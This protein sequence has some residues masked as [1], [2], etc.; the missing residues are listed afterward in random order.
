MTATLTTLVN[1]NGT[2]G[3]SPQYGNLIFDSNG[4][5]FGTTVGGG[6]N[7]YGTVFEIAK[8]A[9]GYASTPTILVSFNSSN[10]A[11]PES[12]LI[13]DA[14]GNLF[15]TTSGSGAGGSGTVF[16]LVKTGSGY[17]S[18]PTTLVTFNGINGSYPYD[19]LIAD[20]NGNLFGTTYGGGGSG[21]TGQGTVFEIAKTGS[22]YASTP[23]TLVAFNGANGAQ[24][25]GSL[26]ADANGNL[27][28]TTFAGGANRYGT[29]FE[30]AKTAN[31]YASTPTILVSFN[32]NNG[33]QPKGSLVIDADGNLFGTTSTGGSGYGTVFEI[34]K[35]GSGYASAPTTL[36]SFDGSNGSQPN[37]ALTIDANG[38]LFG[39][40][41]YGGANGVAYNS[42]T[43][44]EI[45]KTGSGYAS[46]PTT[47]VS[48]NS[49]N[50]LRPSGGLIAD[51]N[52]GLFGITSGGGAYGA[53]TVFEITQGDAPAL[54]ITGISPDN[55]AST[56]DGLTNAPTVTINGTID[57]ADAAQTISVYNG[58]TLVGT[59]TATADGH[60]SLTGVTLAQG[61]NSLTAQATS[62]QGTG[63]SPTYTAT[64]DTSPPVVSVGASPTSGA[65]HLGQTITL[66]L[67][68]NEAVKVS[69]GTPTLILNDGGL[70]TYD[71]AATATLGNPSK[72]AFTYTVGA[73]DT[74]VDTLAIVDRNLNGATITDLAGNTPDYSGLSVSFPG[75]SVRPTAVTAI[76]ASPGSGIETIGQ[77][78]TLTL[79]FNQS[80]TVSGGT[81]T[82]TLNNGGTAVY[83]AAATAALGDPTKIVLSYTVAASDSPVN[84]LAIV[85][86]DQNGA[87]IVDA[88]G[89]GPDFTAAF[90]SFPAIQILS[91]PAL[92]VTGI[93]PDNGASTSDGLTNAPTVTINGTIDVADAA[94]TI[95]VYNGTTLVGT[96]T[97]TADGHWSLTGV[98]LAQG[99]NSLT[100]RA[101][102]NQGTGTS[103]IFTAT[104]DTTPPVVSVG[105]SPAS[106]A[107][108]FG[109][110]ITLVLSFSKAVRVSGGTPTLSLNDGGIATYDAA[111]TAALGNPTK[112]AFSYT[113]GASDTPVDALAVVDHS[114][115][116][117][118]ITDLAG[119]APDYSGL[120]ASLPGLSV[121]PTAV[122]AV[123]ASPAS[124]TES[125]GQTITLTLVF[126]QGVTV[127]GGTPTFTLNNGGT[128]V[129]DAAATAAL[130][131]PTRMVLSYTVAATDSPVNSLA[132]VRGDQNGAVIVDAAGHGPDFTA[133]FTSF[134]AIH[135]Q[136]GATVVSVLASPTSGVEHVGD[137]MTFTIGMDRAVTVSGGTPTLKLSNNGTA[138]YDAAATAALGDPAKLVFSYTVAA[139]DGS[140]SSINPLYVAFGSQNGA[141]ILDSSGAASDFSATLTGFPGIQIDAT[142]Q[143][144]VT[145]VVAS[146]SG[147]EHA[148]DTIVFTMTMSGAVTVS[149][150]TPTFTLNNGGKAVYDAAATAALNDP[151]KLVFK[152]TVA[153]SDFAANGLTFVRGDQNGA[154]ILD[155]AW[156]GPDF[157]AAFTNFP[158]V[159]VVTPATAVTSLVASAPSQIN[160]P[161]YTMT[162]TMTMNRAVT[163]TGGTP[164]LALNDG[165]TA[166]Y[167][168]T[169][170]AALGDPTKL[171][172]T[173][174]VS[175]S[176]LTETS[177]AV[178]REDAN[179]AVIFDQS[180]A[181]PDFSGALKSFPNIGVLT[182]ATTVTSAAASPSSGTEEPGDV[183]TLTY[184]MSRAVTVTGG[185]PTLTLNDGGTATYDAAATAALG[186]PT[187][188]VFSYAVH[189]D[190]NVH[191]VDS[192]AVTQENLNG[193]VISDG[194]ARGAPDLSGMTTSFANLGVKVG[195]DLAN[196]AFGP[197]L[198]L[199]YA[200]NQDNSGGLLTVSDGNHSSVITLLGQYAA[201]DFHTWSDFH[202]GTLVTD[203]GLTGAAAATFLAS[204][205]T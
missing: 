40:T 139:S 99:A 48:F 152:Y 144:T 136:S 130:G 72:L 80:V 33:S 195:I 104:L 86:S 165:G 132:I 117:A 114:L 62:G 178:V 102:S 200:A 18:T 193:A 173:Y 30:I 58:T 149:G 197:S 141:A 70:A 76:V 14:N 181:S 145:S 199:G 118:A 11:N 38:N 148:G 50:G 12:G 27:F 3:S 51:A 127:S 182:P 92:T 37:D 78:I 45:A 101:T 175:A 61:A 23:T 88:A 115:N 174:T 71:A 191:N 198:T 168:A 163:V 35:T 166:T 56:S 43:V 140:V 150:G 31:G 107:E 185:T 53:G 29:V 98:T 15:G 87:V 59:T 5:L 97:A 83:D 24:P 60:W 146:A 42:G 63:T 85:R 120:S 203:P 183:I 156:H 10:G 41:L 34:A 9:N 119:N 46:T 73:S 158:D 125:I 68:F 205:H 32:G 67:S 95:S 93:S 177:L 66:V 100:A 122:T 184:T 123:L 81:P 134:P 113:V 91:T 84:G 1:F 52:G 135:I 6:A 157:S 74:P 2:N 176:D 108:H 186:D 47:L 22:G 204:Q 142:P 151:T 143:V 49:S 189:A 17:A 55:G 28:G 128:A 126:N 196:I 202:S 121:R 190:Y 94:Q 192:L 179:G 109:Q 180:G 110:T 89:H 36:V 19:S 16:E 111:A 162:F 77:T 64:L 25:Y 7:G 187:K 79:T 116:G 171:M 13:V 131:D 105:A 167:D 26:I 39:T 21:G 65:E 194:S 172:F 96:T 161:G 4:N 170:T 154:V 169:A 20:A 155:A 106:G 57:V 82:F 75:L 188:L 54:T 90:T 160:F 8:T 138:T 69:G 124:G 147:V 44:F 103:P 112:L 159:S 129:Y 164:T 137:T 133:A 153:A 201:A